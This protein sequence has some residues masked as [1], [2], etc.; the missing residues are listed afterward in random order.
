MSKPKKFV[1]LNTNIFLHY[2]LFTDIDWPQLLGAS[3]V[4]L[5]IAP[6]VMREIDK[7]KYNERDQVLKE[8]AEKIS[9][10]LANLFKSREE[11]RPRTQIL[12]EVREPD[13][14]FASLQLSRET[15]DDH[16]LASIRLYKREHPEDYVLL[17]T[18]DLPLQVK[19][20]PLSIET[21]GLS[22]EFRIAGE[23][24]PNL[25]KVRE[26]EKEIRE[27]TNRIPRPAL[28]FDNGLN[29]LNF[30]V[31]TKTLQRKPP[32]ELMEGIKVKYPKMEEPPVASKK[33]PPRL[34]DLNTVLIPASD[35]P[36]D[37][38]RRSD[39]KKYNHSLDAFYQEYEEYLGKMEKAEELNARKLE[40]KM[41]LE[42][43]GTAP[44]ETAVV[45]IRIPRVVRLA[46]TDGEF[47]YP[48]A[49]SPPE[50]PK[51]P[52]SLLNSLR[53]LREPYPLNLYSPLPS[54]NR[55]LGP[56]N[57][58]PNGLENDETHY[59]VSFTV[60]QA[61]HNLVYGCPYDL[62]A[63]FESPDQAQSFKIGWQIVAANLPKPVY[64]ALHVIV[65]PNSDE[66]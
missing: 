1:F 32:S 14:E 20:A 3:E 26:L 33:S 6:I 28:L 53:R 52:E 16:L 29:R 10:K 47:E 49:P 46:T 18:N 50:R 54:F 12:F 40:L 59:Q 51:P 23:A 66:T 5:V 55:Y 58:E 42:N 62:F 39:I 43:L 64:G 56:P 24:D 8:R 11:V 38:P 30:T 15:Q 65:E 22:E 48:E 35:Y 21:Q 13:Q 17:V 27:L 37:M 31:P 57:I 25:K 60:R 34:A 19:S 44:L 36:D 45:F 2:T 61:T 41:R 4:T 63:I 7:R 9:A